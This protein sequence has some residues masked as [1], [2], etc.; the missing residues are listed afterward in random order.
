MNSRF[1]GWFRALWLS[2]FRLRMNRTSGCGGNIGDRNADSSAISGGGVCMMSTS[3][4]QEQ[5]PSF[6][7][8]IS[9]FLHSNSYRLNF[10][11]IAPDFI[12][13][14]GGTSV[15]FIFIT[16]WDCDDSSSV[17]SRVTTLKRQFRH[18]YVV[19]SVPT[20]EQNDSFNGSYFKHAMEIGN[21]TFVPVSDPEMGFEKIVKIAHA[22]GVCKRQDVISMMK[23]ERKRSVEQTECFRRVI[24]SI[25]GIDNHD[26]NAK[27]D[28][29]EICDREGDSSA[30]DEQRVVGF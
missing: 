21:P 30:F 28:M 19:V 2:R 5:H 24:T 15:A 3:W 16:N 12:F 22:R 6:I 14:N 11:Q 7:D 25:P 17:F 18:L 23:L 27:I 29:V 8:F 4:K 1:F 26:A 13:N 20:K 9:S 10:L